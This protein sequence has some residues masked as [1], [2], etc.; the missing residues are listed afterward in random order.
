MV[1]KL[2]LTHSAT[3]VNKKRIF[4]R[5]DYDGAI[6]KGKLIDQKSLLASIPSIYSI[7]SA[8]PFSLVIA[9]HCSSDV[10]SASEH[11]SLKPL[12]DILQN[13]LKTPVTFISNWTDPYFLEN[14]FNECPE[15][16]Y[17]LENLAKTKI[18][19]VN[20]RE[21]KMYK[22]ILSKFGNVFVD[23]AFPQW[24]H[25]LLFLEKPDIPVRMAGIVAG[26]ELDLIEF[27]HSSNN[28]PFT[29]FL[30]G[31]ETLQ[32]IEAFKKIG[33]R[34]NNI[35]IS[36]DLLANINL[37]LNKDSY[38]KSIREKII[39]YNS[40]ELSTETNKILE[41]L[42][43]NKNIMWIGSLKHEPLFQ[44]EKNTLEFL[45]KTISKTNGS[46][47]IL[48]DKK[49]SFWNH[50][51]ENSIVSRIFFTTNPE[52]S[53]ALLCEKAFS[54]YDNLSENNISSLFGME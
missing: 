26:V 42:E 21:N 45:Q 12:A 43:N 37:N 33:Q 15:S 53:L 19:D 27:F 8:N 25:D 31:K 39:C 5:A 24:N 20:I 52:V 29:L 51:N 38:A 30:T 4:L 44:E 1:G 13:M 2:K 3:L 50:F 47:Y 49:D 9:S 17:L 11:P 40:S 6:K 22:D 28:Q 10:D 48:E 36:E 16:I 32:K 23:D 41:I 35:I 18:L 46:C 34:A 54:S 7:M 14:F